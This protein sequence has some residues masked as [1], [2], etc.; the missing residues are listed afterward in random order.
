MSNIKKLSELSVGQEGKI[1]EISKESSVRR[2]LMDMGIIQGTKISLEGKAP[3]GD[4]IEVKLRG[5]K[6][7]LRK[8]EAD[9]VSVD[10]TK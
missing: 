7:T 9:A 2:R 8:S 10:V 4:P 5:Y 3:M 6:L 1:A